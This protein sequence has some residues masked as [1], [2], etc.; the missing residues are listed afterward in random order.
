MAKYTFE[1]LPLLL[2][3]IEVRLERIESLIQTAR[4]KDL[5]D[6]YLSAKQAADMLNFTLATLYT[7]VCK[8]EIP[9][10]KKGNRLYFSFVELIEWIEKG[11]KCTVD[12]IEQKAY[13][14]ARNLEKSRR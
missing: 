4:S 1:M 13:I 8:G 3:K 7:K 5:N 12:Q 14:I 9:S 6:D 2:E 11:K 10:Y